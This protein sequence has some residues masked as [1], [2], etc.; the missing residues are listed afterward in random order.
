MKKVETTRNTEHDPRPAGMPASPE[1]A[2]PLCRHN[3]KNCRTQKKLLKQQK[4]QTVVLQEICTRLQQA[5][6][7]NAA[8]PLILIDRTE[9]CQLLGCGLT[10]FYEVRGDLTIRKFGGKTCYYK[11]EVLQLKE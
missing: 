8:E 9:A 4:I 7:T 2:K 5:L 6:A 3:C 1:S 10:K 11:H